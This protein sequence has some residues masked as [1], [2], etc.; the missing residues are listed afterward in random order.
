MDKSG[1]WRL[2]PAYDMSWSYNP[3]GDWTSQHQMSINGKWTD[4]TREDVLAVAKNM[5]IKHA[6]QI[7]DQVN[8]AISHW[9]TL[10]ANYAIPRE[11]VEMIEQTRVYL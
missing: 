2:S 11:V 6:P 4:I 5:N 9:Q 3:Q 1:T 7:I 8:E 10:A